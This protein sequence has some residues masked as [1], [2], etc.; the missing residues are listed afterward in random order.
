[1]VLEV[2]AFLPYSI[3]CFHP[4]F[5]WICR[6]PS[7]VS[8]AEVYVYFF[9]SYIVSHSVLFIT[10]RHCVT[11]QEVYPNCIKCAVAIF[12]GTTLSIDSHPASCISS[13]PHHFPLCMPFPFSC[14]QCPT[15][16]SKSSHHST[17][18]WSPV[19][20]LKFF[21]VSF[22]INHISK[23]KN[24]KNN[25]L[26]HYSIHQTLIF[27]PLCLRCPPPGWLSFLW[28]SSNI[29]LVVFCMCRCFDMKLA[30]LKG[31]P[32]KF[33]GALFRFLHWEKN[34]NSLVKSLEKEREIRAKT[35]APAFH[36]L[37]YNWARLSAIPYNGPSQSTEQK[38]WILMN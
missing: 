31:S 1:M 34:T 4:T 16:L 9:F 17:P 38:P 32:F 23:R 19:S 12:W 20:Y 11:I 7:C 13:A 10:L 21:L 28:W 25:L 6:Q 30:D 33:Y 14:S 18:D 22:W 29:P 36:D 2:E 3:T 5:I 35:K 8:F 24:K 37:K 27:T 26:P 15:V